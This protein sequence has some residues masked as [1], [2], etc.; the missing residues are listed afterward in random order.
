MVALETALATV[1]GQRR[2]PGKNNLHR[3]IVA[4]TGAVGG[5]FGLPALAIELPVSTM[6]IFRSIADIARSEG[7]NLHA[8]DA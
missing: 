2:L 6:V 3:A 5:V 1:D 7:E 4:V 8:I